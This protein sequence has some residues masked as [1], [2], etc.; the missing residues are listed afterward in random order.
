LAYDS[1]DGLFHLTPA[2]WLRKDNEPFP[3]GRIE[4]W[5]YSMTQSSGWFEE[6]RS[7]NCL[8][9][10]PARNRTER[11]T[12]RRQFGWPYGFRRDHNDHVGEPV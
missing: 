8:W 2:G 12:L 4:T 9:V 11:D 7:L 10:D 5:H 1:D 6:R 3:P